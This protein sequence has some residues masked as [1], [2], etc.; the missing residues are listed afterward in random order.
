MLSV[1]EEKKKGVCV[2]LVDGTTGKCR[3]DGWIMEHQCFAPCRAAAV[4]VQEDLLSSL[5]A[6]ARALGKKSHHLL[7]DFSPYFPSY[8]TSASSSSF[9]VMLSTLLYCLKW[10]ADEMLHCLFFG[11]SPAPTNLFLV[12]FLKRK[13]KLRRTLRTLFMTK[14]WQSAVFGPHLLMLPCGVLVQAVIFLPAW[15]EN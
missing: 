1:S 8:S 6:S 11:W 14:Q 13:Q 3:S 7:I 12:S 9:Q 15:I 5:S 10:S 2:L 4:G